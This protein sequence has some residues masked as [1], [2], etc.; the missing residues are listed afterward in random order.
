[1]ACWQRRFAEPPCPAEGR[2]RTTNETGRREGVCPFNDDDA[3][4][5][6]EPGWQDTTNSKRALRGGHYKQNA[7]FCR[8]AA[9]YAYSDISTSNSSGAMIGEWGFRLWAPAI[10][11]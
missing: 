1:M 7:Q 5:F 8:A 11:K 2:P 10:A 3:Q 6:I 9:G 4:T